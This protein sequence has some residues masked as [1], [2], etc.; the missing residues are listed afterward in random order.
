MPQPPSRSGMSMRNDVPSGPVDNN[1]ISPPCSRARSRA[2]ARPSPE[3]PAR[4]PRQRAGTASAA[5]P[6][7]ARP[8]VGDGDAHA[9]PVAFGLDLDRRAI[10]AGKRFDRIAQEI[11]HDAEELFGIGIDQ[12]RVVDTVDAARLRIGRGFGF[13]RGLRRFV[14][15]GSQSHAACAPADVLRRGHSASVWVASATARSSEATR[16]GV[17]F[18]TTGSSMSA[19]RSDASCALARMLRRS[20]WMRA[21]ADA[22]RR[23]PLLLLQ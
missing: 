2:M 1:V 11:E 6:R 18:F 17:S 14:D 9:P 12:K 15:Q 19:R 20:C 10:P 3:P 16:R 23:E 5:A 13:Q 22:Q 8:I 4:T 21:T 7:D